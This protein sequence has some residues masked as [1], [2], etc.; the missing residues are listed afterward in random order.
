M[1]NNRSNPFPNDAEIIDLGNISDDL[2]EHIP[3]ATKSSSPDPIL[4]GGT[5]H[6][7][8]RRQ[9]HHTFETHPAEYSLSYKGKGRAKELPEF[10]E[11]SEEDEIQEFTPPPLT[12][13]PFNAK[14]SPG[15]PKNI[16]HE[17]R[18]VFEDEPVSAPAAIHRPIE[19]G[20]KNV[21]LITGTVMGTVISKMKRK[22]EV[23]VR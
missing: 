17:R 23:S 1:T 8:N 6:D 20:V 7:P 14:R 5:V 12:G 4:L 19:K 15:I 3:R 9:V 21:D 16:V 10:V 22:D 2:G 13:R 18:K 11:A